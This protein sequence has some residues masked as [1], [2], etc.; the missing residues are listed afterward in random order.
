[1]NRILLTLC[2]LCTIAPVSGQEPIAPMLEF[3]SG[4]VLAEVPDGVL[5]AGGF[6]GTT[7]TAS[8]E[9]FLAA[10]VPTRVAR[11]LATEA[12]ARATETGPLPGRWRWPS[13]PLSSTHH[14][15]LGRYN[16]VFYVSCFCCAN[17]SK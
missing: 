15:L 12:P 8:C 3:R 4:H 10:E 6:D 13:S 7:V 1:M 17:R 5:A 14:C 2:L 11:W 9:R 16:A